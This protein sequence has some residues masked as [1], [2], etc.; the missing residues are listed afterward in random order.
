MPQAPAVPC[1]NVKF[2]MARNPHQGPPLKTAYTKKEWAEIQ[3]KKPA[4]LETTF[5]VVE[6]MEEWTKGK[7]FYKLV[8]RAF[9]LT[10]HVEGPKK[11]Q[12]KDE[13]EP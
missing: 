3:A 1:Q 9:P 12:W 10:R 6:K 11:G 13:F 2:G 7:T 8:L 5:W 4:D